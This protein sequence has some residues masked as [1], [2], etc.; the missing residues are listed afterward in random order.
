MQEAGLLQDTHS[1][2]QHSAAQTHPV[3]INLRSSLPLWQS[4]LDPLQ[5]CQETLSPHRTARQ[6]VQGIVHPV[7]K[8][9]IAL[10]TFCSCHRMRMPRSQLDHKTAEASPSA[11]KQWKF[12]AVKYS[13]S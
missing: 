11:K 4:I 10:R 6:I 7:T 2:S 12:N 5:R 1:T 13:T 8:V 3:A 9:Q